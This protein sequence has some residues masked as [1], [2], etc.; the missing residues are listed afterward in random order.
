MRRM[1]CR[2]SGAHTR[3]C[4]EPSG[5]VSAPAGYRRRT[6]LIRCV[7]LNGRAGRD[8]QV[9]RDNADLQIPNRNPKTQIPI[10]AILGFVGFGAWDL[11]FGIWDFPMRL[12]LTIEYAG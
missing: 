2:G 12:K 5:C 10:V 8:T 3:K 1:I 9:C 4:V 7:G 6:S 11:G